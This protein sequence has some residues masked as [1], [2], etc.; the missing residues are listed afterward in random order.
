MAMNGHSKSYDQKLFELLKKLRKDVSKK[1]NLPPYVI[2]QEPSLEEMA[3][4]YP[5]TKEEMAAINGVGMGKVGK[6]GKP[7]MEAIKKYVEENDIVT[8]ADVVIKSAGNKSKNKIFIIQQIDK[9]VDLEEIAESLSMNMEELI[10]EIE[11]ICFSGTKLNIDYYIE[12]VLDEDQED[13]LYDYFLGAETDS[14]VEAMQEFGGDY[15]EEELRL[16]R[17]KFISEYAN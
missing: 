8:A 7:F 17:V 13:E 11:H 14:I 2:F 10:E 3:T 1:K 4:T 9:K 15:S 16:M 5:T 6:F 12:N